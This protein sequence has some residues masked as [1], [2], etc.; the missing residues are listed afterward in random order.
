MWRVCGDGERYRQLTNLEQS[1]SFDGVQL[2]EREAVVDPCWYD[3][4]VSGS[5]VNADPSIRR[6]L[7]KIRT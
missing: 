1:E 7:C 3:K 5:D 4:E 6:G 2:I